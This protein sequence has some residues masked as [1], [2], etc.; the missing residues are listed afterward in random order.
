[1]KLRDISGLEEYSGTSAPSK[2]GPRMDA[3]GMIHIYLTFDPR[4]TTSFLHLGE[5]HLDKDLELN[6]GIGI[7]ELRLHEFWKVHSI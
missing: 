4:N 2:R 3:K 6:A 1:M 7:L 5:F